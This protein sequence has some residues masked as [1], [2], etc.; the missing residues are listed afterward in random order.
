MN[1]RNFLKALGI[2]AAVIAVPKLLITPGDEEFQQVARRYWPGWS[3]PEASITYPPFA[4][5]EYRDGVA[6]LNFGAVPDYD[7]HVQAMIDGRWTTLH[8]L[9]SVD[10]PMRLHDT[11]ILPRNVTQVRM[12]ARQPRSY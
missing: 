6:V 9:P 7:Y 2:G 5:G 3:R 4:A 10:T 1:R 11:I 12:M 8:I